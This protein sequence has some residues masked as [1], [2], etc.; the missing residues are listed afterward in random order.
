MMTAMMVVGRSCIKVGQLRQKPFPAGQRQQEGEGTSWFSDFMLMQHGFIMPPVPH[1]ELLKVA[2]HSLDVVCL[3]N[4]GKGEDEDGI[5]RINAGE[6]VISA[7]VNEDEVVSI[8][9]SRR[10]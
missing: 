9:R 8:A 3:A 6:A 5:E 4:D 10:F 1:F 7:F 2:A